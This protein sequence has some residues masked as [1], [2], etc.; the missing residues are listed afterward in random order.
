MNAMPIQQFSR[1]VV[2]TL[3]QVCEDHEPS[4][5]EALA[6]SR[7]RNA[8]IEQGDVTLLSHAELMNHLRS[9]IESI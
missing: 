9:K 8:E 2:Q 5:S 3:D 7:Q 6:L 1:N 4:E